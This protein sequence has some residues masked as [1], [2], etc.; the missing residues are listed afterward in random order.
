MLPLFIW[1]AGHPAPVFYL[2][3]LIAKTQDL[4]KFFNARITGTLV[5]LHIVATLKHDLIEKTAL[6]KTHFTVR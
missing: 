4:V 5:F 2:P 6:K 3:Q 1:T